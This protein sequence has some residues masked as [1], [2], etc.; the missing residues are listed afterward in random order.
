[1]EQMIFAITDE[2][3]NPWCEPMFLNFDDIYNIKQ[4]FICEVQWGQIV[5]Y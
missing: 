2:F 1:M 5:L 3:G 4:T